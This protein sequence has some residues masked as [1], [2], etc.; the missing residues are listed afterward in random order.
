[1]DGADVLDRIDMDG[2]GHPYR[3]N[4]KS[5]D[6]VCP[7]CSTLRW[8]RKR[9]IQRIVFGT[10]GGLFAAALMLAF[11]FGLGV[12]V[13][14]YGSGNGRHSLFAWAGAVASILTFLGCIAIAVFPEIKYADA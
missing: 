5:A 4:D 2:D 6:T 9:T 3:K 12:A 13:D 10:L 11:F 1:M 14:L 7:D 8:E